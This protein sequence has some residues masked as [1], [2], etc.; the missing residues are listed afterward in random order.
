[1]WNDMDSSVPWVAALREVT[2]EAVGASRYGIVV[3][4]QDS[5]RKWEPPLGDAFSAPEWATFRFTQ[6]QDT[7]MLLAN[8]SSR[9]YLIT[10][11]EPERAQV[12]ANVVELLRTHPD[13][14]GR[15]VY[16]LPYR[17]RCMRAMKR[18]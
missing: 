9:S 5:D 2:S 6:R 14:A 8:L 18:S 16:E 10:L 3:D 13:T 17:T 12:L 4:R 7:D 15:D 11:T 1:V